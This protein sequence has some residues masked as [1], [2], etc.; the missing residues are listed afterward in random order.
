MRIDL[1]PCAPESA[2]CTV[3]DLQVKGYSAGD[4]VR[5]TKGKKVSNT[6]SPNSCP[7]GWKIWS[8][9]NKND[10]T[11]VYNKLGKSIN[12]YPRKPQLIV[13]VTRSDNGC[14][15]CQNYAMNSKVS[16]QQ[17]WKTEDGT[18]W[19]LRDTKYNEPSGDYNANCYLDV[20]NVDPNDVR[21]NDISCGSSSEDYLCQRIGAFLLSFDFI[22][23]FLLHAN[24]TVPPR[25]FKQTY[26]PTA[27]PHSLLP[28]G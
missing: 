27:L 2:D 16:Q 17:E 3:T 18:D 14:G 24:N 23:S 1:P 11:V 6:G 21:F 4:V 9:R 19:W 13:D 12:K 26:P 22:V 20:S 10:W 8:P 15:G 28:S 7:T 25:I 5:V